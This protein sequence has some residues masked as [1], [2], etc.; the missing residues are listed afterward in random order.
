[1]ALNTGAWSPVLTHDYRDS[2]LKVSEVSAPA[3]GDTVRGS[4]TITLKLQSYERSTG[5]TTIY[6]TRDG[7]NTLAAAT[8]S[9]AQTSLAASEAGT[10]HS[11]TWDSL[12]D[13]GSTDSY[14]NV[15]IA[16]AANDQADGLGNDDKVTLSGAFTVDNL[17]IAPA[18]GETDSAFNKT[19]LKT[20]KFTISSTD[21]GTE[22]LYPYLEGDL[23]TDFSS[24]SLFTVDSQDGTAHDQFDHEIDD[25]SATKP[26]PGYYVEN[27][28][29]KG[30]TTFLFADLVD[31]FT[32]D[33]VPTTIT[34]ARAMI[35][36]RNARRV[37]QVS[38]SDT[39][40][41]LN[42]SVTGQEDDGLCD[43]FIMA[44]TDAATDFFV[45]SGVAV[46]PTTPTNVTFSSLGNDDF[47]NDIT[48]TFGS[49]PRIIL[50]DEA[51]RMGILGTTTTTGVELSKSAAGEDD[52]AT[53]TLWI[54]KTNADI[55]QD[56]AVA[57]A[58]STLTEVL[59]DNMT[60]AL[61]DP[62][63]IIQ[64]AIVVPTPTV[65]RHVYQSTPR[66]DGVSF[67]QAVF[68]F[69][70]GE[71]DVNIFQQ[72]TGDGTIMVPMLSTGIPSA[73]EG[74]NAQWRP[75]GTEF[76]GKGQW[77]LRVRFGNVA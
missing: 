49:A 16:V 6:F 70:D 50:V 8:I 76:S 53:V 21:P 42:E 4:G 20:Q 9:E 58:S 51:D 26:I 17:P 5:A 45:K 77:K 33:A 34:D 61:G 13:L 60:D 27:L 2:D 38:I 29:V 25:H 22:T 23:K 24:A 55:Y 41:V 73:Y 66:Q 44:G 3:A 7:G 64:G 74:L 69:V 19:F 59:Y 30:S 36:Q 62:P 12:T 35:V 32:C 11:F 71:A 10:S 43:I 28:T 65:D 40:I 68:G 54:L 75:L 37:Y 47:G 46:T 67:A 14:D 52:D 48:D 56:D 72:Q 57:M 1:M 31:R 39:Q 15:Q 18:W 63:A